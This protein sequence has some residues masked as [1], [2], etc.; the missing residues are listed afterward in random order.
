MN[1]FENLQAHLRKCEPCKVHALIIEFEELPEKEK[2]K[3]DNYNEEQDLLLNCK[4]YNVYKLIP[5][6]FFE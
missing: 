6:D 1:C 5:T 3:F 2:Y 4:K